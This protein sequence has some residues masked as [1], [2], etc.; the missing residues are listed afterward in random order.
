MRQEIQAL[1]AGCISGQ[2][3]LTSI[4]PDPTANDDFLFFQGRETRERNVS[5]SACLLR[6]LQPLSSRPSF[7]EWWKAIIPEAEVGR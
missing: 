3:A 2:P 6:G 7:A 4:L 1:Q 5:K